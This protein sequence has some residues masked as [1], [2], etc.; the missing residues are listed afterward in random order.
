MNAPGTSDDVI[1]IAEHIE[2]AEWRAALEHPP[3]G[4]GA[5]AVVLLAADG[6]VAGSV[7]ATDVLMLNRA[8]GL[9][10]EA[11]AT[12]SDVDRLTRAFRDAGARRW[13][14][15][16]AP[17]A[18]PAGLVD[19][20]LERGYYHHN[21]WIKLARPAAAPVLEAATTFSVRQIGRG[22]AARFARV[23]MAG[24]EWPAALEGWVARVVEHPG[25]RVY[26][27]FDGTTPVATGALSVHGRTGWLSYAATDPR[28]RRRGAQNALLSL[29]LREAQRLGCATVFVETGDDTPERPN[30]SYRNVRRHG[31]EVL[32]R[33]ANYVKVLDA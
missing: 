11:P 31:F 3:E 30:P 29:R 24:F 7:P 8:V 18:R 12:L 2:A 33:R 1:R 13:M 32:Y 20:L 10:I 28:Y 25:M 5:P 9:G 19:W 6:V 16:V 23:V 17:S 26:M 21:D 14:I 4:P 15:Q 22:S 27:A